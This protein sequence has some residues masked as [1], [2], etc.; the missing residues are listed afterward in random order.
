MGTKESFNS[1]AE[2]YDRARP[3]CPEDVVDWILAKTNPP[4]DQTILEIGPGTGQTTLPFA[5]KGYKIHCVELGDN[6][7]RMLLANASNYPVTVD[8]ATFENWRPENDMQ[9]P[10][11]FSA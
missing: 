2:L 6:L 10:L 9:Y 5:V 1:A 4:R 3:S 8:V 11:I 7:A